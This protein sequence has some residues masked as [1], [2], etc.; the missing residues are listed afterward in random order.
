MTFSLFPQVRYLALSLF[1]SRSLSPFTHKLFHLSL[2]SPTRKATFNI[3]AY[4]PKRS[5]YS[6]VCPFRSLPIPPTSLLRPLIQ[7]VSLSIGSLPSRFF[8]LPFSCFLYFPLR[9][10]FPPIMHIYVGLFK[11][12]VGEDEGVGLW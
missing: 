4:T 2:F 5:V 7:C 9:L 1:L 11:R 8:S 12:D 6:H 10:T 3:R